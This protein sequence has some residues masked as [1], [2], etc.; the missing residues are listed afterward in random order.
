[1]LL[2][3]TITFLHFCFLASCILVQETQSRT[4][5]FRF[6]WECELLMFASRAQHAEMQIRSS[7]DAGCLQAATRLPRASCCRM[8]MPNGHRTPYRI[9]SRRS[10]SVEHSSDSENTFLQKRRWKLLAR[11]VCQQWRLFTRRNRWR[12]TLLHRKLLPAPLM[13]G[14]I[15]NIVAQFI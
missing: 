1:M 11:W 7:S 10:P 5:C 6:S 4:P 14:D 3:N 13:Q 12:R 15:A 8:L 2:Q 9:S